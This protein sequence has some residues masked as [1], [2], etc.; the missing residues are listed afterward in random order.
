MPAEWELHDACWLAWPCAED[1]W[2]DDLAEA[3]ESF[4]ALC[5][6]I[7]F[8][9]SGG[10][11]EGLHILVP[12]ARR[13]DQAR[14]ALGEVSARFFQIPFGDIWLRDIAP[15]FVENRVGELVAALFRF[16]GWGGKYV[17]PHDDQVAA[18]IAE[19]AGARTVQFDWVLEGGAIEVDGQGTCL[20]TR[21]CLLNPNRN[22]HL[23][24]DAV[25]RKLAEALGTR[26]VLWLE[27]GLVNDHTDGHVDTLARFVAPGTAV[28]MEPSD[29]DDPN[30]EAL[31][32]I[33]ADLERFTDAE[34][35]RLEV[36]L[37]PSPGRVLGRSGDALPASYVN[38][39]IANHSVAVPTYGVPADGP[40]VAAIAQLFPGRRTVGIAARALLAGGGAFHCITQQ[41]PARSIR[42]P[43][44]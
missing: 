34:G 21:Q 37:I 10:R 24:R 38:F 41:Q 35:R 29:R 8:A 14:K 30:R 18:H 15:L 44:G 4:T 36:R 28:C 26:R 39:Y 16:N 2:G 17:L 12:D 43:A 23:D 3:R 5:H 9:P 42:S 1:L 31:Q 7:A 11:S 33:V 6:A 19:A 22:P 32:A 27:R 13:E 25:E 20:T 40:A